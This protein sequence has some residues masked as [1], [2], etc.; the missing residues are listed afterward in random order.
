M[1]CSERVRVSAAQ[2]SRADHAA[3]QAPLVRVVG[4]PQ[5]IEVMTRVCFAA[6]RRCVDSLVR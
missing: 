5:T 3:G 2:L 6:A 1:G 4:I